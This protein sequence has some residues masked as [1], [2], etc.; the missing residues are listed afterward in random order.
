MRPGNGVLGALLM[1]WA[2]R[3]RRW[4]KPP[5]PTAAEVTAVGAALSH[6]LK[7]AATWPD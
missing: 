4:T 3:E 5:A 6:A 2:M 7:G 1:L